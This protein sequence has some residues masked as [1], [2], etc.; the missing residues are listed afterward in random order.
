MPI[1]LT[2]LSERG[3]T[4]RGRSASTAGSMSPPS[5]HATY[6]SRPRG[7]KLARRLF[8]RM[9]LPGFFLLH[10]VDEPPQGLVT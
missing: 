3:R 5:D 6:S 10:A 9:R 1:T 4:P 8:G 2:I 7:P